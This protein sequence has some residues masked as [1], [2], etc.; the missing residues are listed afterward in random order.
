MLRWIFACALLLPA[1]AP[2]AAE[3]LVLAAEGSPALRVKA[4]CRLVDAAG[5]VR[6]ATFEAL[7]PRRVT[8]DAAAASC[9]L[10]KMDERG[11]LRASLSHDGRIVVLV[12]TNAI[13]G[14]LT[15][16]TEGPWGAAR[17]SQSG[18]LLP[19]RV[20]RPPD[21]GA[22]RTPTVPPLK[23]QTVP[24]LKGTTVPQPQ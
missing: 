8:L 16:R 13:Y 21:S 14:A 5:N 18:A 15:L 20:P 9:R 2:A 10:N 23:G 12:Q 22:G 4:S 24:P 17:A 3:G 11:L 1:A 7:V 6:D 19:R